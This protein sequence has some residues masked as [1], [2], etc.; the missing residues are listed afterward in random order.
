MLLEIVRNGPEAVG[1]PEG[2]VPVFLPLR[3]LR[4]LDAGLPGFIEQELRDPLLSLPASFGPRLVARGKLLF[5]LDGLDEVSD[6]AERARVARWIEAARLAD[7]DNSFL[8]S[9]RFAGYT[10]DV[11]LDAGFIELHVRPMSDEQVRSFVTRWYEVVEKATSRDPQ[12]AKLA[13]AKGIAGLLKILDDA[14]LAASARVYEMTHNPLLLTAICLVHRDL[15]ELPR[16]RA[17]LYEEAVKVLLERWRT[18]MKR[19][20]VVLPRVQSLQVL[21]PVARWMHEQRGRTRASAEELREPVERGLATLRDV[22]LEPDAF[23]RAIRDESGLLTGW[24]VDRYGFMHLGFQEYLTAHAIKERAFDT[25]EVGEPG[26][27]AQLA[28]RFGDS[29]WQEVILLLLAQGDRVLFERFMGEVV[30]QP[31]FR[32][33]A[34]S[35]MMS[36][37]LGE[38]REVSSRPFVALVREGPR[39]SGWLGRVG[40][41]LSGKSEAEDE[42]AARQLVA[43]RLLARTMPE[44]LAGLGD[45]LAEHRAPALRAWWAQWQVGEREV[46]VAPRGGVELVEI[47]GGT[48]LM[49]SADG[50]EMTWDDEKPQHAVTLESFLLARTP[51]TNAQYR[52]FLEDP[53]RPQ[54]VQGPEHWGDRNYN[55]DEQPVVGVSWNDAQAYCAWAGLVLPTEAQWEY[56]CRAGTTTRFSSGDTEEDL[57][58]VGWY[59]GN[60]GGQ[61]HAVGELEPNE[62]GLFDMHGNV[63]EWCE[64]DW[65]GSY[66]K[67]EHRLGD[68]LRVKPVGAASRVI[69]GGFFGNTVRLARSAFRNRFAP[70]GRWNSVGF[71]PA[72]GHPFQS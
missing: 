13:A 3:N 58:K 12:H 35:P 67:A 10:S 53:E 34:R 63:R 18:V 23:L 9:C 6:A 33:W 1:L 71:R 29:W 36:M 8:V 40:R 11:Q 42:L 39:A 52:K 61:L 62:F 24:G 26:E 41:W 32:E 37:C 51:V 69:R 49:G 15:G 55:Q 54:G 60:S 27:L 65:V 16:A 31:G 5:L 43:A 2:T 19:L 21:Q 25:V 45:V 14:E 28:T 17:A 22:S 50:D 20:P 38:A 46:W 70:G 56:A 47:P 72:Q 68:G 44:A 64:D 48:F 57:A 7:A 4:D 30:R 66:E 59:K